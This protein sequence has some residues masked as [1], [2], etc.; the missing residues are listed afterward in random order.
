MVPPPIDPEVLTD[1]I[2]SEIAHAQN[3]DGLR[4]IAKGAKEKEPD[5]PEES[6]TRIREA[7]KAKR[8]TFI[9]EASPNA[10]PKDS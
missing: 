1:S 3:A 10:A 4:E 6:L 8:A 9:V 2:I 7:Y 5:L